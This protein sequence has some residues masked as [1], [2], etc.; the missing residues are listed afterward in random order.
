MD[1]KRLTLYALRTLPKSG[2]HSAGSS[3]RSKVTKRAA[4]MQWHTSIM[5]KA[6]QIQFTAI[7]ALM[8]VSC[9]VIGLEVCVSF[10]VWRIRRRKY[11]SLSGAKSDAWKEKEEAIVGP[12]TIAC[13]LSNAEILSIL[14]A[15]KMSFPVDV[16]ALSNNGS[17]G[18][19]LSGRPMPR[20]SLK[21]L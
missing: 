5:T 8:R 20:G 4:N 10:A 18:R 14:V 19:L 11:S 16:L 1:Q 21:S 17:L 15:K 3:S 2:G 12:T 7:N 6:I 9:Q 13:T